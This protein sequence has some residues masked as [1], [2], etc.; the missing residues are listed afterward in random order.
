MDEIIV[1]GIPNCDTIKKTLGWFRINKILFNFHDYKKYGISKLK[2]EGWCKKHGWESILN[3]K[4]TT[5]RDLQKI[6]PFVVKDQQAAIQLMM[7]YTSIIKRPVVEKGEEV[8]IG[9]NEKEYI[10]RL[11]NKK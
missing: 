8:I 6:E 7:K 10:K 3:K 11:K 9:F 2:L 1:Y 5:W 4:S